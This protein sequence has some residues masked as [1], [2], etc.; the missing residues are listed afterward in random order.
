[1]A[2]NPHELT[3]EVLTNRVSVGTIVAVA[4][5]DITPPNSLCAVV[6]LK[7]VSNG[8]P[9]V[10][11]ADA[12]DAAKRTGPL[13]LVS[14][15]V[16]S[17]A[18]V[19]IRDR[20]Y[21][22][23]VTTAGLLDNDILYL[24]TAGQADTVPS[25]LPIPVGQIVNGDSATVGS[26][27]FDVRGTMSALASSAVEAV[28][29]DPGTATAIP[30]TRSAIINMTLAATGE[31]NTLAIPAFIGQRLILNVDTVGAGDTRI[32]TVAQG[33]NVSN[34][35]VMTFAEVRDCIELVATTVAGALRWQVVNNANVALS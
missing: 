32:I 20:A 12:T 11:L 13:Y 29:A 4:G 2:L 31:T 23:G 24:T 26:I 7:D 15:T 10:Y 21:F 27:L 22:A 34:N 14:D 25:G 5:E 19:A 3:P 28:V 30:V 33:I 17:G 16:L 9:K 18:R 8:L 6:Y 1:M 35:T